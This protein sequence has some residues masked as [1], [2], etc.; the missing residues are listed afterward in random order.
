MVMGGRSKALDKKI[1]QATLFIAITAQS[2]LKLL[3]PADQP[4]A[5][6]QDTGTPEFGTI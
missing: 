1:C 3:L 6:K 5:L 2:Y 4:D